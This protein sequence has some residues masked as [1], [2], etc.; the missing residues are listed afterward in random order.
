[1]ALPVKTEKTSGLHDINPEYIKYA[2]IAAGIV[3][4]G[5]A[6]PFLLSALKGGL[7]LTGL[8]VIGAGLFGLTQLLPLLGQKWAN[9]VLAMRKAEAAKNPIEQLQNDLRAKANR[10]KEHAKAF[11]KVG[12]AAQG[13]RD[14]LAAR[15]K[16]R[17]G[18]DFSTQEAAVT[19]MFEFYNN[20]VADNKQGQ[21]DLKEYSELIEDQIFKEAFAAAGEAG[22]A[23][24]DGMTQER[25]LEDI[26]ADTAVKA[27]GD[28]FNGVFA[29][30]DMQLKTI[31]SSDSLSFGELSLDVSRIRVPEF[32]E[33]KVVV[34]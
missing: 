12:A 25:I 4:L 34:R 11:E 1:M 9:K 10:I 18:V 33:A 26:L 2:T 14:M 23:A 13:M 20:G 15:K 6:Y 22:L 8:I 16:Q 19:K 27:V 5:L 32:S 3:A 31:S 21:Q 28:R 7:A 17:P 29:K 30:M 24:V